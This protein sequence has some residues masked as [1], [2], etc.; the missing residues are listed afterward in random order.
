MTT[1]MGASINTCTNMPAHAPTSMPENA[2]KNAPIN[3]NENA[4]AKIWRVGIVRLSSFGDVV[5]SASL[6]AGFRAALLRCAGVD[7]RVPDGQNAQN[8]QGAQDM[9]GMQ[10]GQ[11]E[12]G[13]QGA[14]SGAEIDASNNVSIEW[15]VDERFAGILLDSPAIDVLHP[16][17]M[18]ALKSPKSIRAMWRS[19]RDLGEFDLVLD[20]QGLI[21]SAIVGKALR[22]R[23]FVGFGYASARERLAGL[24]Y[25]AR[26]Q[27]PYDSN[28]LVR[29]F[30]IYDHALRLCGESWQ[31][32]DSGSLDSSALDSGVLDSGLESRGESNAESK[33][34]SSQAI[35]KRETQKQESQMLRA[36]FEQE[37]MERDKEPKADLAGAFARCVGQRAGSF[38]VD[39]ARARAW[40]SAQES[41]G[42][43]LE[44][45]LDPDIG[46]LDSA[47][48]SG[49]SRDSRDSGAYRVLFVLEAS[50]A[51]KSYP[52]KHFAAL[53]TLM[54]QSHRACEFYLIY[55]SHKQRALE[56]HAMLHAS[57]LRAHL[58]PP[59]DFTMLKLVLTRMDCVIGGDTGVTHLA[60]ALG[61][62][63]VI[64]LLGN[65]PTTS[66]KNMSQ[67]KLSRVL[68]G[69][70]IALSQSGS[71]EIASIT[72]KAIHTIW[73]ST[74]A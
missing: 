47:L 61:R 23:H 74:Q 25:S 53:A 73:S 57:C 38:G 50:T 4:P 40:A 13:A 72:P 62:A 59:L 54:Q 27:I 20:L 39:L 42:L 1:S 67:T 55:H 58:L 64:T 46:S 32:L 35:Q 14:K 34:L 3:T 15:F 56:L 30:A 24:A 31:G 18:R 22:A 68:L 45:V 60:W 36:I 17:P 65:A 63:R 9:K 8:G 26:V 48:D 5:V 71:F 43:A 29:N 7:S 52:P 70:P 12:R 41:A 2:P 51:Q 33:K 69:N 19:L 6:L 21:K 49:E 16:L 37:C 44:P 28:I 66:G 10:N 11:N